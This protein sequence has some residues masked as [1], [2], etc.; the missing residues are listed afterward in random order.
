M[1]LHRATYCT[2]VA[3]QYIGPP[4][5]LVLLLQTRRGRRAEQVRPRET[6]WVFNSPLQL[7]SIHRHQFVYIS[8]DLPVLGTCSDKITQPVHPGRHGP[9]TTLITIERAHYRALC[10]NLV[11][12]RARAPSRTAA[13]LLP[14]YPRA[15][16]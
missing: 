14:L 12:V 8:S 1:L 16:Y 3:L 11:G 13:L 15:A 2:V 9:L 4:T 7:V 6:E 5:V 10:R